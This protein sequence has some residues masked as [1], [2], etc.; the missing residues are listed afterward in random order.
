MDFPILQT[1]ND[2]YYLKRSFTHRYTDLGNPFLAHANSIEP[3]DRNSIIYG[4]STRSSDKIFSKLFDY[5]T[6]RG[7]INNP[8]IEFNTIYHDYKWKVYA[9]FITNATTAEDNGYFFN[10]V[11]TNISEASFEQYI[12]ELIRESSTQRASISSRPTRF[13]LFRPACMSSTTHALSLWHEWCATARVKKLI[14]RSSRPTPTRDILRPGMIKTR[15]R[16]PTKT[17]TD[18]IPTNEVIF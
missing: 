5:R 1:D 16:T 8:I 17:Q 18:G 7:F 12:A 10:Y 3:L 2:S 11:W 4:H 13:S 6:T 9:V 15:N 14:L